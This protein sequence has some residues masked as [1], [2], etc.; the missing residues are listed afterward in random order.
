LNEDDIYDVLGTIERRLIREC[1]AAWRRENDLRCAKILG[2]FM[3]TVFYPLADRVL[4]KP[5]EEKGE[6]LYAGIIIMPEMGKTR[7]T[8][9]TVLALG[10]DCDGL[11]LGD[12]VLF[13][14]YAGAD[15]KLNEEEVTICRQE[16]ILGVI[17]EV[18]DDEDTVD[19][20][21][22]EPDPES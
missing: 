10:P 7:S 8:T 12:K 13:G 4:I 17:T 19:E 20:S 2:E 16:D 3:P 22:G 15:L 5:D 21:P 18:E 1:L 6:K 11:E 14:K 9:G